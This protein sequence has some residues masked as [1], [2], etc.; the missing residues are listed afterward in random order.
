MMLYLPHSDEAGLVGLAAAID[1][2]ASRRPLKETI[3]YRDRVE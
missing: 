3:F 1:A 2:A